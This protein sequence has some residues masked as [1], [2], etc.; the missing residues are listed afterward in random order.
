MPTSGAMRA[1]EDKVKG[2]FFQ[3]GGRIRK[4]VVTPVFK[5]IEMTFNLYQR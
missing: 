2:G 1:G 5:N 4:P 3:D